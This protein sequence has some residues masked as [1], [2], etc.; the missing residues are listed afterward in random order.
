MADETEQESGLQLFEVSRRQMPLG[1]NEAWEREDFGPVT[2]TSVEYKDLRARHEAQPP[3]DLIKDFS[4]MKL[5][6]ERICIKGTKAL[7]KDIVLAVLRAARGLPLLPKTSPSPM[8][9]E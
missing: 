8:K 6:H 2:W 9:R 5:I 1:L 4:I 7:T 3:V